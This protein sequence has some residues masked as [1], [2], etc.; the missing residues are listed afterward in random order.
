MAE[1]A[2]HRKSAPSTEGASAGAAAS[3][4]PWEPSGVLTWTTDF[5]LV[6][7]YVGTMHGVVLSRLPDAQLV[8]LTHGV[9]AQ[10]I[11]AGAL[12]LRHAWPYFPA[13][14]VHVAV[15]DPGVGTDRGVLAG[16]QDGHAFVAPDN[17]LLAGALDPARALVR[18]VDPGLYGLAARSSTFH[19]RDVFAPLAAALA[20]GVDP[21]GLGTPSAG[22]EQ[23]GAGRSAVFDLDRAG[24]IHAEVVLIDRFGNAITNLEPGS[25]GLRLSDYA[26]AVEGRT[27]PV[28]DTYAAVGPGA[29]LALVDSWGHLEIAIRDGNAARTLG[30]E[31]GTPVSLQLTQ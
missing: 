14:S 10:D 30:L 28:V 26:V 19:G 6:D 18:E 16:W 12:Q 8:D 15:V 1:P 20:E 11:A 13:G 21:R 4:G 27:L 25:S 22:W 9:P 23:G 17:G 7:A 24:S 2:E 3:P 29:P 5:G 31:P